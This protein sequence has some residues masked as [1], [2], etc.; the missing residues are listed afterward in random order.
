M[1]AATLIVPAGG[2]AEGARLEA[3]LGA[4]LPGLSR[5]FLRRVIASG[6]VRVNGR[7]AAKGLRLRAGDRVTLPALPRRLAPEP[8]LAVPVLHEDAHLVALD[9]PAGMPAHALHPG[10]RGTAAAFLLARYPEVAEVGDALAPGL[11]HRLDTGTSGLLLAARTPAAHAVLRAAFRAQAVEKRYLAV[12]AGRV[13]GP[14]V[15]TVAVALAHDRRRPGR[16]VPAPPGARAWPAETRV[17]PVVAGAQ[18]SLV[19]VVIR[20]GVTHQVRAHLALL[21]HPVLGDVTYGGPPAGLPPRCQALHAAGLAGRHPA[22][23][24][25]LELASPLPPA[26]EALVP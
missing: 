6:A 17:Q 5:R 26:L 25:P 1:D 22:D 16:M 21:G 15:R 24:R 7:R 23:G 12:V 9:K 14:E 8:D 10:Q 2:A 18:R 20:T 13:A 19:R 3:F 11:V 4:A